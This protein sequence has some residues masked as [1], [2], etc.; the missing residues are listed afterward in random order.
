MHKLLVL[1][2]E[3]TDRAAFIDYYT[4]SH[5]PLA[6]QLPGILTWS[7]SVDVSA[8]DEG[9]APYF[10]VFEAEF[11]DKDAFATAMASQ[12]GRDVAAD[13]SNYAT[14]GAVIIDFAISGGEDS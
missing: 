6:E 8:D 13:V 2:P 10:A 5:L 11:P 1:Y 14:G 7:Y 3:P 4:N 12:I 9:N